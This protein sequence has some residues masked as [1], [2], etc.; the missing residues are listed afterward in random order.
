[1]TVDKDWEKLLDMKLEIQNR[2]NEASKL[3]FEYRVKSKTWR[4][5]SWNTSDRIN[6]LTRE[7]DEINKNL[8]SFIKPRKKK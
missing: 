8:L 5:W 3:Q 2:Q 1:M 6:K 4:K 7:A